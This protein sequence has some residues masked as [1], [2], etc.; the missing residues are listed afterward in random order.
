M[1]MKSYAVLRRDILTVFGSGIRSG[2]GSGGGA[3]RAALVHG[4]ARRRLDHHR[5]RVHLRILIVTTVLYIYEYFL[6]LQKW[7]CS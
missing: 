7:L 4:R 1:V 2:G 5:A 3:V 6:Y